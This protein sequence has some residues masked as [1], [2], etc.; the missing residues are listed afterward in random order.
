MIMIGNNL[1]KKIKYKTIYDISITIGKES[2]NYPGDP[3]FKKT[4]YYNINKGDQFNL[5]SI[6]MSCH[7]GTHIDIPLHFF[8]NRNAIDS[9]TLD[10]FILKSRVYSILNT[11]K[12]NYK[13]IKNIK[14]KK[15]EAVL[16]KTDNSIKN[17]Y[18]KKKVQNKYVY[19]TTDAC[20]FLIDKGIKLI[21]IDYISVDNYNDNEYTI[22][23]EL[24]MKNIFILENINLKNINE[25]K[26]TLICLPL[27]I[28]NGEASPVRA[29]LLK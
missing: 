13:I 18:I 21:G 17:I 9:I 8:N 20:K 16:F 7:C 1:L 2:L 23:K 15:N 27:K 4:D 11:E 14:I 3:K 12:I 19:I 6:N 28:N 26:Y 10:N 22:H 29:V 24:L 25:G 5:S